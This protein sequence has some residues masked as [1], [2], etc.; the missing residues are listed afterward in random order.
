MNALA[1]YNEALR[2]THTGWYIRVKLYTHDLDRVLPPGSREVWQVYN[3][4]FNDDFECVSFASPDA[5]K[6][7]YLT[8]VMR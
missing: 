4:Y 8:L 1:Y 5:A 2:R 6:D 3:R 7:F